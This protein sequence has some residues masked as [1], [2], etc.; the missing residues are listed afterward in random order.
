MELPYAIEALVILASFGQHF[1]RCLGIGKGED[2]S[3]WLKFVQRELFR[4]L[5]FCAVGRRSLVI[6][7]AFEGI[8]CTGTKGKCEKEQG[9]KDVFHKI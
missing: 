4:A 1:A 8:I 2:M 7:E 6:Q 5:P 3:T 9:D